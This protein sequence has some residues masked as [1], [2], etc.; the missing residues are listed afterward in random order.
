MFYHLV[1]RLYHITDNRL[2]NV[3]I[4]ETWISNDDKNNMLINNSFEHQSRILHDKPEITSFEFIE[5]FITLGS[6]LC[7]VSHAVCEIQK[8]FKTR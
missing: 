4:T 8:W 6:T 7:Y 3:W 1:T 2:D 5:L